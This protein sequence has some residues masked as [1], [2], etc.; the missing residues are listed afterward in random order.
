M[1]L[2]VEFPEL[3]AVR[4]RMGAPLSSWGLEPP[5]P[6]EIEM[7]AIDEVKPIGPG[8]PLV[9][10]GKQ[11]LLYIKDTRLDRD[12]LLNDPRNSRRFHIAECKTLEKMRRRNRLDRY[13][14][15]NRTNGIFNVEATD[16][17]TRNIE[18]LEAELYVCKN[19]LDTIDLQQERDKW[20][21]FSISGFFR[22]HETFFH[23]LPSHTDATAPP[24]GYSPDWGD[25]SARHR[26][27]ARWIC[28]G[29][30]VN[31][32]E[33]RG[34]LHCHHK[35]GVTS[36]NNSKNLQ[37]LCVEC[38]AKQPGHGRYP[39]REEERAMLARLRATQRI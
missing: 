24:G 2:P 14:A 16:Q 32:A 27:R 6:I 23:T 11:V 10:K 13:V 9:Y 29:C 20:P 37:A 39:P 36:N 1:K 21:E 35:D 18:A 7:T 22:D 5:P 17:D 26:Q 33:N 12:I 25:I 28:E 8:G 4:Q 30:G 3:D 19:C 15:T 34:L 38:H 31:L